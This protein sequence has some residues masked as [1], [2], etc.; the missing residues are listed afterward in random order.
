[1]GLKYCLR[2]RV[3]GQKA[4]STGMFKFAYKAY[5]SGCSCSYY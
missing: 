2:F 4:I 1:M 3:N 5:F